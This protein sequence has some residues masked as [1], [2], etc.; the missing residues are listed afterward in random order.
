[1]QEETKKDEIQVPL[2]KSTIAPLPSKMEKTGLVTEWN[3]KLYCKPCNLM[4]VS[5]DEI[6]FVCDTGTMSVYNAYTYP[7]IRPAKIHLLSKYDWANE[8]D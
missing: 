1:M 5:Y 6:D 7:E 2:H 4:G 3:S 8:L